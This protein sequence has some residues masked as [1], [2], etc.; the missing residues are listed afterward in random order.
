MQIPTVSLRIIGLTSDSFKGKWMKLEL[1]HV[2]SCHFKHLLST[3]KC[4]PHSV[5]ETAHLRAPIL[6]EST[7]RISYRTHDPHPIFDALKE[8]SDLAVK[9]EVT[10]GFN[11]A[12]LSGMSANEQI[13]W[14]KARARNPQEMLQT[15]VVSEFNISE[16]YREL[17]LIWW[18][19]L[20]HN[21]NYG[22]L[23]LRVFVKKTSV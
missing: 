11:A 5:R 1:Y 10:R 9:E 15:A 22:K 18:P 20:Y 8:Q 13:A 3:T 6:Q 16:P 2:P 23:D 12:A 21:K 14:A 17:E 19:N 4:L 7:L